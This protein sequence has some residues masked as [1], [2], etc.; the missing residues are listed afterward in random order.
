MKS[1]VPKGELRGFDICGMNLHFY[2]IRSDLDCYMKT[3]DL[4][5]GTNITISKLH[6]SCKDG[7]H[8]IGHTNN[9]I[10]II[11]GD[12]YRRVKDLTTDSGSYYKKIHSSYQG[13]DHY[14]STFGKFYVLFKKDGVYKTTSH[15]T[16]DS[17][18]KQYE[19]Q[20]ELSDGLYYWGRTFHFYVMKINS[21]WG[22]EYHKGSNFSKNSCD[23]IAS[24]HPDV[25]NFFPGGLS[26]TKGKTVGRWES[27][28]T[29]CNDSNTPLEW[30]NTVTRK[31]G[32]NKEKMTEITQN[33]K[34][35]ASVKGT[36]T[37]LLGLIAK[38]QISLS[39]E[40]GGSEVNTTN[41]SWNEVTEKEEELSLELQPNEN[42]YLWQ[43]RMEIGRAHV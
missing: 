26:I 18:E 42:V 11:K 17:D 36:A 19:L 9:S 4:K 8:Y 15:L 12:T 13:G 2:I 6:P 1:I 41:E 29:I 7:D 28:K 27:L 30:K 20:P 3:T 43:Y 23:S 37:D 34:I 24:V 22:P 25:L 38:C 33:W 21:E 39:A 16:S 31:V 14:F 32:Y 5:N 35:A 10:Y 40:Y